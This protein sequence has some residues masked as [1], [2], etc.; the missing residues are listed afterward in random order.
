MDK[1][2]LKEVREL[3]K[4]L[5][6]LSPLLKAV[7]IYGGFLKKDKFETT[8]ESEILS[9]IVKKVNK[10]THLIATGKTNI[11]IELK[12]GLTRIFKE[13][14]IKEPSIDLLVEAMK[15]VGNYNIKDSEYV[16]E[17]MSLLKDEICGVEDSP[18][19]GKSGE[20]FVDVVD[21]IVG[22]E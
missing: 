15:S 11:P 9:G 17:V 4:P 7:W 19:I 13:K 21:Y 1:K 5:S 18:V 16:G 2:V 8:K 20:T 22:N 10:I 6:K 14:G 3:C 12:D